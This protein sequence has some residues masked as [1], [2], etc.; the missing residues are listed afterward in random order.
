VENTRVRH[1]D[2]FRYPNPSE[3]AFPGE[4]A[5][6]PEALGEAVIWFEELNEQLSTAIS[7]LLRRGEAIGQIVT[8]ELSFKGKVNLF[9]ALF[10]REVPQSKHFPQ[11]EELAGACFQVE[12]KRNQVMHSR[13]RNDRMALE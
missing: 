6:V 8:A 9:S 2:D 12:Q 3:V 7:F 13:W 5:S 1:Y 10:K 4:S 11:L